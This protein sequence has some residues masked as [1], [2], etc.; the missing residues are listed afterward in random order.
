M[1]SV[2][3]CNAPSGTSISPHVSPI[4]SDSDTIAYSVDP[5]PSELLYI[6]FDR[7]YTQAGARLAVRFALSNGPKPS[8]GHR[9]NSDL[10]AHLSLAR[11][12]ETGT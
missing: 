5:D 8:A 11:Y 7:E 3:R 1:L 4:L 6:T 9:T 10:Y 2:A 12:I